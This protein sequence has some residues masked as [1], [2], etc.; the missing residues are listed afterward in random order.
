MKTKTLKEIAAMSIGVDS[1]K[2][3]VRLINAV[4]D[5][6]LRDAYCR[7]L[8]GRISQMNTPDLRKIKRFIQ[9]QSRRTK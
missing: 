2:E 6:R 4:T 7:L 1:A 9:D 5:S 3:M 8:S